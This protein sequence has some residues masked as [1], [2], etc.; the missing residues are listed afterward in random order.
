MKCECKNCEGDGT[1]RCHEC[2]GTGELEC[3]IETLRI[4]RDD[5]GFEEFTALKEDAQ[6][7]RKQAERLIALNPARTESYEA[8]LTAVIEELNTQATELQ[9]KLN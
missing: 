9:K 5:D 1:V 8:Q 2:R 4:T 7:V 6:R 3:D